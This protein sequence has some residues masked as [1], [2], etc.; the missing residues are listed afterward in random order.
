MM[1]LVHRF[2]HTVRPNM[3]SFV[4]MSFIGATAGAIGAEAGLAF[5]GLGD[6]NSISWGTMLYWANNGGAMLTSQ[7]AWLVAP[8]LMLS[9]ITLSLTLIN[10][11]LDA[12]SNPHLREE[13]YCLTIC[14]NR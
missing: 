10:F 13:R 6:P 8:T 9:L 4:V 1:A 3:M 12:L 14:D 2:P 11:G 7:W 5:L